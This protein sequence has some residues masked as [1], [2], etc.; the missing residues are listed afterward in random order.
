MSRNASKRFYR[1]GSNQELLDY[2]SPNEN[3]EQENRWNFEV[4]WEAANKVGGIYTVIRSK[5][6]VSVEEM[7]D[8]Y[9]LLGPYKEN[10]AKTEIEEMDFPLN[11]P[12]YK[13]VQILRDQG[14]KV[15]TGTWLVDGN[16]Q[17]ILFDIGSAAWK[18]DEYKQELWNCCNFGIPHMDVEANDAIILGYLVCQFISEFRKISGSNSQFLPRIVVHCHEWQA[19]VA[20]IALRTRHIDVATV[21]TTH[22]TL[23]G[24]YLCAGKTDFYNNLNK[25]NVDEEAG[26][27]QIYHR[28]CME[29]A[30]A[31]MSHVFTT[32]SDITGLEAEHLLKRVPDIITPN[33]LNVKKFS[34]LHEFQ[35]LHAVNK[36]KIHEFVRGHFYGH[37]D[38][39]LDKTLYFFIAGR[40]EFGNKGADIFIEALARLNHYIKSSKSDVTVVAFLIFPAR[41]NNF[42]VESLRGH[43]VTKSLRGTISD[44]QQ[45]IGKRMYEACLSGRMPENKDLCLKEDLMKIK[46][47]LYALQRNGLPPITTHNI[48]DDWND[49]VLN[50]IRRCN[51]FNTVNDRVKYYQHARIKAL[52]KM[53][54]ELASEFTE[55]SVKCL[56]YPRPISEPSSPSSSRHTT[57]AASVQGSD[58]ED[59]FDEEKELQ[60]LQQSDEK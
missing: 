50:A 48:I 1:L 56:N 54:P 12:I 42:N 3:P 55:S 57:P 5:A 4:S 6:Y 45:K 22:A 26:K 40:Y 18:L 2:M 9:C 37:F 16:P 41:T 11:S 43:A 19:G 14:Y 38:F 25:F 47:C 29:R 49:P 10:C 59:E 13:T 58:D 17:I 23:L 51:L 20:L 27:R 36:E 44:I 7:G 34:A 60:E 32:V 8:Q 33:G 30:A 52:I 31:H 35:N 28:Y 21:F 46:R 24:R 39:D 15:I 53:Y